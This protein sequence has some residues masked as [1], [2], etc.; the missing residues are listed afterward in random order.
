MRLV[1]YL[2]SKGVT[3]IEFGKSLNPVASQAQIS[4]WIIGRSRVSVARA[5]EIERLTHGAVRVE[6][7]L[8]STVEQKEAA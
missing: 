2:E 4:H 8:E 3:Q 1:D 7:W 5:V 6:D